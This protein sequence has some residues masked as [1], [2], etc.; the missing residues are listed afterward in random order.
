MSRG[1]A[2]G[3]VPS[4]CAPADPS[5]SEQT[6]PVLSRREKMMFQAME[7]DSVPL[8]TRRL[9]CAGAHVG[10]V[11]QPIPRTAQTSQE[12]FSQNP[13]LGRKLPHP[14]SPGSVL[15]WQVPPVPIHH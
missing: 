4:S 1:W 7:R 6:E 10:S 14:F 5:A 12:G 11:H 9:V 8:D 3:A 2:S 15:P 13:R